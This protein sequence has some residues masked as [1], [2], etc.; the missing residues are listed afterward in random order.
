MQTF[1]QLYGFEF[2]T[3]AKKKARPEEP[4]TFTTP[5]HSE[6]DVKF[7][8]D[9]Y[10][11]FMGT[12][13]VDIYNPDGSLR[14]TKVYNSKNRGHLSMFVAKENVDPKA[15]SVDHLN[16]E[17]AKARDTWLEPNTTY[18]CDAYRPNGKSERQPIGLLYSGTDDNEVEYGVED[19]VLILAGVEYDLVPR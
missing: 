5:N 12:I 17:P 16:Q 4:F 6:E 2:G 19:A 3:K 14:F 15:G 8:L 7:F 9:L 10:I 11:I 1:K 13:I 18:T